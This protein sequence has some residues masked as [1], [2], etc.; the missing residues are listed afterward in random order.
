LERIEVNGIVRFLKE[1]AL[2]SQGKSITH[3]IGC[4]GL[5]MGLYSPHDVKHTG[6]RDQ[7]Q[8]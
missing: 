6:T 5:V 7:S 4:Q 2:L 8:V 1:A 3:R